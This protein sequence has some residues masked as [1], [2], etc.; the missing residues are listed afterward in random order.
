MKL[1]PISPLSS[2][3]VKTRIRQAGRKRVLPEIGSVHEVPYPFLRCTFTSADED[4]PFEAPSWKPGAEYGE[5]YCGRQRHVANGMGF[6]IV[7]VVGVYQP[8]RFPTRV[9]YTRKWV[10]PE[11]NTFGKNALKIKTVDAFERL[12][13]GYAFA[14]RIDDIPKPEPKRIVDDTG[15]MEAWY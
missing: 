4:G 8:G 14:L 12:I 7:T 6:Q 2:A 3:P 1:Q 5:D 9:F 10:D 13:K 11:G 15:E